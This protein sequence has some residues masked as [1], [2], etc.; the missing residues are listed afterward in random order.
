LSKLIAAKLALDLV[1]V[2]ALAAYAYADTFRNPFD[3]AIEQADGRTVRGRVFDHSEPGAPVDLQLFVDGRFAAAG[4]ADKQ[5]AQ[6]RAGDPASGP[7][8]GFIFE[9]D[10][11]LYGEHEVRVYAVRAGRGG[12]R[13]TLR[14]VG[15]PVV[16][17]WR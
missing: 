8:R 14:Q 4:L 2:A 17:D 3:G 6:G 1:F 9:F 16:F 7:G 15:A 5:L 10:P 13:R 11:P 12:T